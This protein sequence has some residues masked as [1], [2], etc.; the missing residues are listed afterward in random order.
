MKTLLQT[1]FFILLMTTLSV[2]LRAQNSLTNNT[3][4]LE[5][6]II[7]DGYIGNKYSVTYGGIVFNGNK[8]AMAM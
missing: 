4:T 5:V 8:N 6:T 1:L 2:F 7:D 3:G